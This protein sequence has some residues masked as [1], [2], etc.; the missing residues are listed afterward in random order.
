[1]KVKLKTLVSFSCSLQIQ[2]H[3]ASEECEALFHRPWD[4]PGQL[5]LVLQVRQLLN[6]VRF[7]SVWW[8]SHSNPQSV[9][10]RK[11]HPAVVGADPPLPAAC[12]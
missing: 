3:E 12:L 9:C 11:L 2:R 1:M 7:P 4:Y 8:M 5:L 6:W 10:L